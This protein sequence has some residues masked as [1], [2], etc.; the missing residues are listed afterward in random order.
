MIAG[1]IQDENGGNH[2]PL[3]HLIW[4]CNETMISIDY[5]WIKKA[6]WKAVTERHGSLLS[7]ATTA[8]VAPGGRRHGNSVSGPAIKHLFYLSFLT[9]CHFICCVAPER[10][11]EN[12]VFQSK[13]R[14]KKWDTKMRWR[15][16]WRR[17]E[18]RRNNRCSPK[19]VASRIEKLQDCVS[20]FSEWSGERRAKRQKGQTAVSFCNS[21]TFLLTLRHLF[22]HNCRLFWTF[23]KSVSRNIETLMW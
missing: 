4:R 5:H 1:N 13:E 17:R 6:L 22:W 20:L 8:Y 10:H 16:G 3:W 7:S 2:D 18:N 19:R 9:V 21:E 12:R 14:R 23:C 15:K 11:A